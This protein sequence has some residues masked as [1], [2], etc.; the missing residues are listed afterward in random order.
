MM[1][2]L[3]LLSTDDP[4]NQKVFVFGGSHSLFT[5]SLNA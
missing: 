5:L 1:S 2:A 4:S 3:Q